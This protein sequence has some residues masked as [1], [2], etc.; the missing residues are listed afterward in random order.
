M[1]TSKEYLEYIT[2]QLSGLNG[3]TYKQMMGEYII[4]LRGRIVAYLCDNRLLIKPVPTAYK[5]MPEAKSEPP[6]DGAK[7]MLLCERVDDS[8][9]LK[10]L[11]EGI[12]DELPE[13]KQK[14]PLKIKKLAK[15]NIAAAISLALSVFMQFEAPEYPS[16][17]VEE[18]KKTLV[19]ENYI[20][21]LK[22]YGAFENGELVGVLAM[23]A[24]QHISL[25]FVKTEF[26]KKGIGRKLFERMKKD[27]PAGEITVNSSPYAVKIY[28][29]L[30]FAATDAEQITNGIRYTPMKYVIPALRRGAPAGSPAE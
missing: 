2:E 6:Y 18:F 4:Y 24:P 19:D 14:D 16:E 21:S 8:E 26:H 9:F 5:M 3:V 17:G 29:R 13:P 20:G 22:V 28:E 12:Y 27:F 1:S 30:G 15:K 10:A 11:F 23:R 25:F 7:E